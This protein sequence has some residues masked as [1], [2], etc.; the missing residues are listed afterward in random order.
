MF[1]ALSAREDFWAERLNLFA[2]LAPV[3]ALQNTKSELFK[4]V[5][6]LGGSLK[7]VLA[8]VHVYELL[9]DSFTSGAMKIVCGFFEGICQFGEGFLITQDPSLDDP[10]R[11]Q[12]YM[13]HFPAG[14]SVQSF[15]HFGQ[16]ITHK[17]LELFDWGKETNQKKYGQDT[18]PEVDLTKITGKVPLA[19]FVGTA[20]DLGDTT[21]ARWARDQIQKGGDAI[22]LYKEVP[23][24]HSTFMIGKDMSYVD[25]LL[26]VVKQYSSQ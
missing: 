21:D 23:A 7:T 22:K 1:Y 15:V 9:G 18:P 4:Y 24:G 12:V 6:P 14:A 17:K 5:A 19:M 8:A 13:A 10:D 25:D 11:F 16:L 3:T 26:N 2:S 20:D